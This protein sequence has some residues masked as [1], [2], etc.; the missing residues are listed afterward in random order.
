[1]GALTGTA[2]IETKG[3]PLPHF[4]MHCP[5]LS[6]PLAFKT[7]VETIPSAVPYLYAEAA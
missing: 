7:R 2:Q 1:M 6:L 3:K 4:D 5:L